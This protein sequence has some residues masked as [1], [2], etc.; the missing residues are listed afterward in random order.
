MVLQ[1]VLRNELFKPSILGDKTDTVQLL[2]IESLLS[3]GKKRNNAIVLG[4]LS[5]IS[6]GKWFL[7]DPTGILELDLTQTRY[8]FL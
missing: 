8:P 3:T 2:S 7:E 4:L 1:R 6:E 5:Q